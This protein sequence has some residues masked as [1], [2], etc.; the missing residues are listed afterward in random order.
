MSDA[1][2]AGLEGDPLF[3]Q[4]AT[5]FNILWNRGHIRPLVVPINPFRL[6]DRLAAQQGVFLVPADISRTFASNLSTTF[7]GTSSADHA[8]KVELTLSADELAKAITDLHRHN[9]G[10][11]SLF[12]GL[13]GLAT[14]LHQLLVVPRAL[15]IEP[16]KE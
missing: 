1:Q 14:Q 9:I 6:N 15:A 13:G 7:S 4:P 3:V 10:R 5:A 12:P 2:L 11:A 16:N 8:I